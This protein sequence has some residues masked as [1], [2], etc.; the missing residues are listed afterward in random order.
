MGSLSQFNMSA[1]CLFG[2]DMVIAQNFSQCVHIC[3]AC[4]WLLG[5]TVTW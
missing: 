4:V 2:Y 3:D 5:G 1:C